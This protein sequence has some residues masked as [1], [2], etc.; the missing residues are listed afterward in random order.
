MSQAL[1]KPNNLRALEKQNDQKQ[2]LSIS[3]IK[4]L[5]IF[6]LIIHSATAYILY[7]HPDIISFHFF[8]LAPVTEYLKVIRFYSFYEGLLI[9]LYIQVLFQFESTS[10]KKILFSLLVNDCSKLLSFF[11][12]AKGTFKVSLF[13]GMTAISILEKLY[14]VASSKN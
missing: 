10:F 1:P 5:C 12:F 4:F 8:Q 7:K 9:V 14:I 13:A 3:P 11:Y 2:S 6:N